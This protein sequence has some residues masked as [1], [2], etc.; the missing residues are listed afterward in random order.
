LSPAHSGKVIFKEKKTSLLA[1]PSS[2]NRDDRDNRFCCRAG[3]GAA[4]RP[5]IG[6]IFPLR[7]RFIG[8]AITRPITF[9]C[10]YSVP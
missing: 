6:L 4:L 5:A 2:D 10:W 3:A 7:N 8:Q 9:K 1:Y